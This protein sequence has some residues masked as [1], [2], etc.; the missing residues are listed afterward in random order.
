MRRRGH[1]KEEEISKMSQDFL[2]LCI[3]S[4]SSRNTKIKLYI[5]LDFSNLSDV[6]LIA[7]LFQ[8]PASKKLK[9]NKQ[10]KNNPEQSHFMWA[11]QR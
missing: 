11:L 8:R 9:T 3:A 5:T 10:T 6:S 7:T 2:T 1:R 4:V